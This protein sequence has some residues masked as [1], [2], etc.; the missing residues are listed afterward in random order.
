MIATMITA[1]ITSKYSNDL[2]SLWS[3][4]ILPSLVASLPCWLFGVVIGAKVRSFVGA[5]RDVVCPAELPPETVDDVDADVDESDDVDEDGGV[6]PVV[7]PIDIVE[8]DGNGD[9]GVDVVDSVVVDSVVVVVVGA[10]SGALNVVVVV[11]RAVVV[12]VVVNPP[13]VVVTPIG[14]VVDAGVGL[15]AEVVLLRSGGQTPVLPSQYS[16]TSQLSTA[17]RQMSSVPRNAGTSH[18]PVEEQRFGK[19]QASLAGLEPPQVLLAVNAPGM[20]E[21]SA[22]LQVPAAWHGVAGEHVTLGP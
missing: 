10:G 1:G 20:Q 5:V 17:V 11:V 6:C 13:V 4:T 19:R 3:V 22:L 16:A 7:L 8:D 18:L 14:G 9:E 2:S 15:H 21:P 12:V